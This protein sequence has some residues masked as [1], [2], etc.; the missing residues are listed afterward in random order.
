M[1]DS[2][3]FIIGVTGHRKLPEERLPSIS[4]SIKDFYFSM[5]R[6]HGKRV[7]VMSSLAEGA[8]TLCARLALDMEMRLVA[9]LPMN[10]TEY[11]VD[12]S[13]GVTLAEFDC[14][15]SMAD[16]TFVVAPSEDVP[17]GAGRGFY[18]RQ[19][20]I[21]VAKRCDVMLAVWGG[22]ENETP[23]GA[24]TWETVKLAR[25]FSKGIFYVPV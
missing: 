10:A 25:A 16:E 6:E 18:Y 23:D 11:R 17:E 2:G 19:A 22:V 4:R 8:D 1:S 20:G 12:F 9:A 24:G 3:H 7:A 13:D 15:L 5:W 21:Y 14:L